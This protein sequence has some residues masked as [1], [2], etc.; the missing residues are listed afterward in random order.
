MSTVQASIVRVN[1]VTGNGRDML[2][3]S[4]DCAGMPLTLTASTAST[5]K[6]AAFTHGKG[7]V[8]AFDAGSGA[9]TLGETLNVGLPY[10]LSVDLTGA[11]ETSVVITAAIPAWTPA[12]GT[13]YVL[14]DGGAYHACTYTSWTGSTFTITAA[15]FAGDNATAPKAV[16]IV[17]GTHTL[18]SFYQA[19]G[20]V[21]GT[22]ILSENTNNVFPVDNSLIVGATSTSTALVNGTPT[23]YLGVPSSDPRYLA[24]RIV[25]AGTDHIRV[26]FGSTPVSTAIVATAATSASKFVPAG[27]VCYFG[28]KS[29]GDRVMYSNI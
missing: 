9:F 13:I 14:T 7:A 10:V 2:V 26:A 4:D 25:N 3:E 5:I 6:A 23:K 29:F 18:D 21:T 20:N 27:T 12:T 24:W 19:A 28:V 22:M 16:Y 15:N 1:H 8:F 17:G 11:A